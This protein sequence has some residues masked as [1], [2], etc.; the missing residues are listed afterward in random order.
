MRAFLA[1]ELSDAARTAL[2]R[3]QQQLAATGADVKWTEEENLHIT[4]RFLREITEEQRQ[5]IEAVL[6]GVA[7]QTNTMPVQLTGLGAFPSMSSP[8]VLWVGIG[9]GQ[10]ALTKIAEEIERGI[11]A[12][13]LPKADHPFS[14][15]V[16][17]GRVRSSRRRQELSRALTGA[18]WDPPEPFVADHLT[19]VQSV[20]APTGPTYTTLAAFPFTPSPAPSA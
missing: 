20:L 17:L 4:M 10:E 9:A 11:V 6:R 13:G 3:L 18:R 19:L 15:H 1:V 12:L 14:A 8:R 7:T 16:T 5:G 2:A